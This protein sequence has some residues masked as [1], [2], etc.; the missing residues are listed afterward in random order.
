M[1]QSD[2]LARWWE[3]VW[4]HGPQPRSP[5]CRPPRVLGTHCRGPCLFAP[6]AASPT[7]LGAPL[8]QASSNSCLSPAQH[9]LRV[10]LLAPQPQALVA[11]GGAGAGGECVELPHRN[12]QATSSK[13]S[14]WNVCPGTFISLST[15]GTPRPF[16][17]AQ[18]AYE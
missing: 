6:G 18:N 13:S 15:W 8:G 3:R 10:G 17:S 11:G 7:K 1:P 9:P 2:E 16:T 5:R 4:E 12:T 14:P